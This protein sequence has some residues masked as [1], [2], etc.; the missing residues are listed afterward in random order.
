VTAGGAASAAEAVEVL[1]LKVERCRGH[2]AAIQARARV[3]R[4][5]L[6]QFV[7]GK[8]DNPR[9]VTMYAVTAACDEVLELVGKLR[10]PGLRPRSAGD[11]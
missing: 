8:I 2:W 3:S 5:W 9:I 4:S 10:E 7:A 6:T 1:R 11:Y